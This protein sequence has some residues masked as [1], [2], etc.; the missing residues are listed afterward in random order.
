MML[1]LSR[2]LLAALLALPAPRPP[3]HGLGCIPS[4]PGDTIRSMARLAVDSLPPR[5]DLRSGLPPVGDQGVTQSCVAWAVGYYAKSYQEGLEQ[6][7][8]LTLRSSQF[9]PS[10][11]YNQRPGDCARDQGMTI[12]H[13]LQIV[14]QGAA[15]WAAMPW[16]SRNLCAQPSPAVREAAREYRIAS[17]AAVPR[18]PLQIKA[19]LAAGRPVVLGVAVYASMRSAGA[20][21]GPPKSG[22]AFVGWHAVTAVGYD[23]QGI[24]IVNSWGTR[25]GDR[26]YATLTDAFV[27]GYVC[28]AWIMHDADATPPAPP[29]RCGAISSA[30]SQAM[31]RSERTYTYSWWGATDRGGSGIHH[32]EVCRSTACT[33]T[34]APSITLPASPS[35]LRIRAIDNAGNASAWVELCG[36][37]TH[38]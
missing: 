31:Q 8:P 25:W 21:I 6:Q 17:Y 19:H 10:Y 13:A 15:T 18:D 38:P 27:Q 30:R 36:L 11:I 28:E 35:A 12:L 37:V 24:L 26:G 3:A 33:E 2:I 20:V 9:S 32:Y 23:A 5:V 7:W 4:A 1:T 14:S 29:S 34:A 22:D 16:T